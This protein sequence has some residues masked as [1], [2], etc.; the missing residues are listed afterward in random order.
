M[1]SKIR[2]F[3]KKPLVCHSSFMSHAIKEFFFFYYQIRVVGI[4][5]N[6]TCKCRSLW[7]VE[8]TAEQMRKILHI[9][10]HFTMINISSV[11]MSKNTFGRTANRRYSTC[12]PHTSTW[13]F[14]GMKQ[15]GKCKPQ[16][17]LKG[18]NK[19]FYL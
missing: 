16:Q 17:A 15:I 4:S 19:H 11:S 13:H 14:V 8:K 18:S 9:L 2:I 7:H 12:K 5:F 3:Y 10:I 1:R 6:R